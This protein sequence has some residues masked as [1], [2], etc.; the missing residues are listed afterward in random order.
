[1]LAEADSIAGLSVLVTGAT[2]FI[3]SHLARRLIA[4]GATV[5][6]GY[7]PGDTTRAVRRDLSDTE[8]IPLD[9]R[10]EDAVE[11]CIQKRRP[12]LIFHMAARVTAERS[13][14]LIPHMFEVNYRG[15]LNV[16]GSAERQGVIRVVHMGTCEEY[17][18]SPVPFC[19]SQRE[20]PLSPY[21]MSKAAAKHICSLYES[22][23]RLSVVVL[24]PAVVYGPGETRSSFLASVVDAY[25][26]GRTPQMTPGQQTRDFVYVDDIVDGCVRAAVLRRASGRTIN[27]GT[28]R[29]ISLWDAAKIV[30][31]KCGASEPPDAGALPYRE[32]EV[33]RYVSSTE[34]A[35][36]VLGWEARVPLEEG[37]DRLLS[38]RRE[39]NDVENR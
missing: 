32:N 35:R 21:A 5:T 4:D 38:E 13:S 8:M 14:A 39:R 15:T 34:V 18:D 23:G 33:M 17:G 11:E 6:G 19:E 29:E 12:D 9:V 16:L 26:Q 10:D 1:V 2:G 27:L 3:G 30:Q 37:I 31:E 7:L 20:R 25:A 36:D 22:L 28:G 24:R